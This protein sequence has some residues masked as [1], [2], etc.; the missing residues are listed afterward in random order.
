M[1]E[2]L[3]EITEVV[4]GEIEKSDSN[5]LGIGTIIRVKILY[6]NETELV[7]IEEGFSLYPGDKVIITTKYGNDL[8]RILG[9]VSTYQPSEQKDEL[10]KIIRVATDED[11]LRYEENKKKE[12]KAF[13]ICKEKIKEQ[14][15]D[16][17]LIQAHY[18]IDEPK[19]L[20][21]FTAEARVDFRELVKVLVSVFKMRIELR[22]IGV[23]DE[24]RV[25][26]GV[27]VC[28]RPFCCSAVT[29]RLVPVSIKMAKEQN[30]TLNSMKISGPCGRLLCCLAYEYDTYCE[31]RKNF[32]VEGTPIYVE[33]EVFKLS[34][35]NVLTGKMKILGNEGQTIEIISS[36]I[37]F[38]KTNNRWK[39]SKKLDF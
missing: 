21:F 10:A 12:A 33:N 31:L 27:G 32:P 15:L 4:E 11:I 22:Q 28:G 7:K 3:T 35:I 2:H 14:N 8:G 19:I 9:V 38:D 29:D 25:I 6:S 34:E 37:V 39:L 5:P 18:L 20:F 16:M 1:D 23:R 30:L 24:A 13:N 17:K 26:G 36:D